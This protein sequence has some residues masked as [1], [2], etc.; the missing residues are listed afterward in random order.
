[1]AEIYR[2]YMQ[3]KYQIF[4]SSTFRDLIEERQAVLEAILEL[5]PD[6]LDMY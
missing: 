3:K 4:I 1:M 5:N 2:T 6:V